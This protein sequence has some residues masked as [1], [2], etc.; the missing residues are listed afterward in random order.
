MTTINPNGI[1]D[2]KIHYIKGFIAEYIIKSKLENEG[3]YVIKI[4]EQYLGLDGKYYSGYSKEIKNI[5]EQLEK[6]KENEQLC[7]ELPCIK[8]IEEPTKKEIIDKIKKLN[9]DTQ[10]ILRKL[11]NSI[12]GRI[13]NNDANSYTFTKDFRTIIE[14]FG[15]IES[16]LKNPKPLTRKLETGLKSFDKESKQILT[17]TKLID[18]IYKLE[19]TGLP[20]FLCLKNGKILFVE[21]KNNSKD[22][23]KLQMYKLSEFKKNNYDCEIHELNIDFSDQQFYKTPKIIPIDWKKIIR[24]EKKLEDWAKSEPTKKEKFPLQDYL[25]LNESLSANKNILNY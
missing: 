11:N 13:K 6:I 23:S 9:E 25:E 12:Y 8:K 21:A 15:N 10:E 4:T 20:D 16:D 19:L 24:D 5:K 22:I 18:Q 14:L 1:T 3:W 7:K 17:N 2:P